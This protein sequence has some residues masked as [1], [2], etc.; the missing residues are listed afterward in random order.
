[1][2]NFSSLSV[3]HSCSIPSNSI[4]LVKILGP[5]FLHLTRFRSIRFNSIFS[6]HFEICYTYHP[7]SFFYFKLCVKETVLS[8]LCFWTPKCF[9]VLSVLLN[10]LFVKKSIISSDLWLWVYIAKSFCILFHWLCWTQLYFKNWT[11]FNEAKLWM[12]F[13]FL[14]VKC[15]S[16]VIF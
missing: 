6:R 5:F 16:I 13:F 12:F 9:V 15:L 2:S 7:F 10:Y 14:K 3:L 11:S 1:M 4:N 8:V